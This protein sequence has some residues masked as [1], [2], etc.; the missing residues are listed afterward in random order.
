MN[1]IALVP[2]NL[3]ARPEPGHNLGPVAD[4]WEAAE[5]WLAVLRAKRKGKVGQ[6]EATYR[7]HLAK[8]R[9]YCEHVSGITLSRWNSLDALAFL[10]FLREVPASYIA[11]PGSRAH[12]PNW[13]PF[14]KQPSE[15]SQ[16]DIQRVLHALFML[17]RDQG[18]IR[19][20]PLGLAGAS[21]ARPVNTQR[22]ISLELYQ[23]I[24]NSMEAVTPETVMQRMQLR[25]DQFVFAAL[26]GLGLRASELVKAKMS[27]FRPLSV[28]C[29]SKTYWVFDVRADT[30]KGSKPRTIPVPVEVFAALQNYRRAFGLPADPGPKEETGLVMSPRT[31]PVLISGAKVRYTRDR[32]FFNAWTTVMTRQGIYE[33]VTERLEAAAVMLDASGDERSAEL[34]KASPHWL[35]HTF[36]KATLLGGQDLRSVAGHLGVVSENGK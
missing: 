10:K 15:S 26:R 7:H 16:A 22:A 19:F 35:R 20:I 8:I 9:W 14:R 4:D 18:Y 12:R 33:I 31:M 5:V 6:T 13:T 30:A 28:R 24:L 21:H 1:E 3:V 34:R 27:A 25:R 2:T 23:L 36:A 11:A 29:T 17:W 32:Q